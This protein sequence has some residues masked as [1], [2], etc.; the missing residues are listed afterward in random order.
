MSKGC[1]DY[2]ESPTNPRAHLREADRLEIDA[3]FFDSPGLDTPHATGWRRIPAFGVRVS[4]RIMKT[5]LSLYLRRRRRPAV[6]DAGTAGSE[7]PPG[8]MEHGLCQQPRHSLRM[9]Q[10]A[11]HSL[12]DTNV[13]ETGVETHRTLPAKN[14][15][16]DRRL[17]NVASRYRLRQDGREYKSDEPS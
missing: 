15:R 16:I 14:A 12:H 7:K 1:G 2:R 13:T 8:R 5:A 11:H 6:L 4:V 17:R 9:A 10:T 3:I